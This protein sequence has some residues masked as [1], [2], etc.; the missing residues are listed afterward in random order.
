MISTFSLP[1]IAPINWSSHLSVE[2]PQG[3]RLFLRFQM[4]IK[5]SAS[6][7]AGSETTEAYPCGRS[8]VGIAR[9]RSLGKQRVLAR[10]GWAGGNVG[11]SSSRLRE[12]ERAHE[13]FDRR[14]VVA[15]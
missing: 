13:V 1:A 4:L 14:G 5:I 6:K 9:E 8:Q 2:L 11:I 12:A 3:R 7:A 10:W 15:R